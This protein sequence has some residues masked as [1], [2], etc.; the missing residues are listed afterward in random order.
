M[1]ENLSSCLPPRLIPALPRGLR[2]LN[3][4]F[5]PFPTNESL[6]GLP[7]A[8]E[9]LSLED[10]HDTPIS[11]LPPR[12]TRLI[13]ASVTLSTESLNALAKTLTSLR[14]DSV[15]VESMGSVVQGLRNLTHLQRNPDLLASELASLPPYLTEIHLQCGSLDYQGEDKAGLM[16]TV[17]LA[18]L[19]CF[20]LVAT[21]SDCLSGSIWSICR[22][23]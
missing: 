19:A 5:Y 22:A 7:Q 20:G 23:L 15:Q 8:L 11:V 4:S 6:V 14:L 21:S 12:L 9:V 1:I 10:L 16:K 18:H 2:R 17:K 13:A 3:T